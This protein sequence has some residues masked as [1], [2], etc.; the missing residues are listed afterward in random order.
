MSNE[1]RLGKS[2]NA[3][4]YEKYKA[5][6]NNLFDEKYVKKVLINSVYD[7]TKGFTKGCS[8]EFYI[9]NRKDK[10]EYA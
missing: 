5:A 7:A 3:I 8:S 2:G 4:S 6:L 1:E 10:I 9:K